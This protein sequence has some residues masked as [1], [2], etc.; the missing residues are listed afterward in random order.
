MI[1][2]FD[3]ETTGFLNTQPHIVQLAA[4]LCEPDGTERASLNLIINNGV[5]VPEEAA[6]VH[7]LTREMCEKFGT[8]PASALDV[9]IELVKRAEIVAAHN[10][11]FDLGVVRLNM[12][13]HGLE[14][15]FDGRRTFCT[16]RAATPILNLPPTD[17][18]LA[19][20]RNHAKT[21][22]LGECIRHFFDEELEGAHDAMVDVRA[23]K[24]VYFALKA[25]ESA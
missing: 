4:L 12:D 18:M 24:R 21:P 13:R 8:D 20:G 10:M 11:E 5:D 17:R 14:D 1:L 16:M 19:A 15:H 7:G 25:G 23:C 22:N 2:F 3:T 9:F 6:N